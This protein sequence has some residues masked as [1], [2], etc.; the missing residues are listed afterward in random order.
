MSTSVPQL[1][2]PDQQRFSLLIDGTYLKVQLRFIDAQEWCEQLQV[3]LPAIAVQM[4]K[5]R[6]EVRR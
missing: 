3:T 2:P 1:P 6:R 4:V 5:A